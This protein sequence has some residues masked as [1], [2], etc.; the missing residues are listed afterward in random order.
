MTLKPL[1]DCRILVTP[2]SYGKYDASLKS[3][4]ESRV[5]EVIYN[6]TGKPLSSDQV[7]RL[8]PGI[9]G[10]IAGLDQIDH[11]A[12]ENA[13]DLK[14]ISRYGVGIDQID[15]KKAKEMRIVVTNTPGANSQSVAELT[16]GLILSLAR[17]IPLGNEGIRKGKWPRLQG[18]S[19]KG[20]IVGVVGFG[21]IGELVTK[22]LQPFGCQILVYDPHVS[23]ESIE[24]KSAIAV[25]M[26]T[27]K[28][29]SDFISLHIPLVKETKNLI[30]KCFM[31]EMKTGAFIINTS[32]GGIINEDDLY[33]VLINEHLG[34]AALD[35]YTDEP[36]L[37]EKPLFS[38]PQIIFTPHTGAHTDDA[39]NRMGWCAFDDCLRVLKGETPLFRVI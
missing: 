38:L 29:E 31:M 1:I 17:Q 6:D 18:Y 12:L 33:D 10:Y 24:A 4:L 19:L 39:M 16:V 15:I 28:K 27:I 2:T 5:K 37:F 30:D 13:K 35:V 34:G 25:D 8:I 22:F 23:K 21:A 9:D 3:E 20:K 7:A 26:Q 14:V 11:V 36:P 32:R